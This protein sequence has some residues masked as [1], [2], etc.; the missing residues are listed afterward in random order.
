MKFCPDVLNGLY[1]E[2]DSSSTA[3]I[4]LCCQSKLSDSVHSINFQHSAELNNLRNSYI[5]NYPTVNCSN[6]WKVEKTHG[7]SRRQA[8]IDWYTT[9]QI[10]VTTDPTLISLDYN[11][12]NICNLA[13]ITCGPRFSSRWVEEYK[14]LNFPNIIESKTKTKDNTLIDDLDLSLLQR[15]YFNGGEPLLTEDHTDILR[16]VPN[17]QQLDVMYNTNGTV[18]PSDTVFN[19]W[20]KCKSVKLMISIDA[21]GKAFNFI[22]YPAQWDEVSNNIN[23]ISNRYPHV[24]YDITFT[25]GLHNIFYL[26]DTLNWYLNN[27]KTNTLGDKVNFNLHQCSGFSYGGDIL[28]LSNLG[29]ETKRKALETLQLSKQFSFY[30]NL[31]SELCTHTKQNPKSI[32][33]LDQLSNLRRL[34]WRDSLHKLY[35]AM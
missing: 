35:D 32:E 12:E 10:D 2:K 24:M 14:K 21:I 26:D 1:I 5:N 4:S 23:E 9:R 22:R 15:I 18:I 34:N 20:S 11:T 27:L 7:K 19:I 8:I 25:V 31:K 6:C 16:K 17:L 33:Y 30:K 28:K 3:K 29:I 13:C